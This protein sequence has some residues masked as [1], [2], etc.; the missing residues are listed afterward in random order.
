MTFTW[1]TICNSYK[2][3][4]KQIKFQI[5]RIVQVLYNENNLNIVEK[6]RL[7]YFFNITLELKY[8]LLKLI[9][10]S[11]NI[12]HKINIKKII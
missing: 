10:I 12:I 1:L 2:Q 3:I 9:I 4:T 5:N 11:T 8:K 6:L 7:M